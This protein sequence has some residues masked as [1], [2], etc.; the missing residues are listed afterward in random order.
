[1]ALLSQTTRFILSA[2]ILWT[3]LLIGCAEFAVIGALSWDACEKDPVV[4]CFC[5]SPDEKLWIE[6]KIC[7]SGM[8]HTWGVPPP[9]IDC[10]NPED[11]EYYKV[12]DD[13]CPEGWKP[14][15]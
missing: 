8:S 11:G 2:L 14:V 3:V 10:E 6:S 12:V 7:P 15:Y 1:M 9:N 5:V 4:T 13:Q